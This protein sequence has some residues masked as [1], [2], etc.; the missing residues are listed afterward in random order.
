M[1]CLRATRSFALQFHF[2]IRGGSPGGRALPRASCFF[3]CLCLC[4]A[5]PISWFLKLFSRS[6][7][8]QSRRDKRSVEPRWKRQAVPLGTAGRWLPRQGM[9]CPSSQDYNGIADM[10]CCFTTLPR[11]WKN[12][13]QVSRLQNTVFEF[14]IPALCRRK[15]V[16]GGAGGRRFRRHSAGTTD[17]LRFY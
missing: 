6:L 11:M 10:R 7:P 9:R 1:R 3:I 12:L 5:T 16:N 4:P 15:R 2:A 13:G 8:Q 17:A 14:V